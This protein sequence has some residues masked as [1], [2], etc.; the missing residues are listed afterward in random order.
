[1]HALTDIRANDEEKS[2]DSHP[3]TLFVEKEHVGDRSRNNTEACTTSESHDHPTAQSTCI[4]LR[5]SNA[6][7]ADES[8]YLAQE[9]NRPSANTTAERNPY[10][11]CDGLQNW[12][13]GADVGSLRSRRVKLSRKVVGTGSLYKC[14]VSS[15]D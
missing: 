15:G 3:R 2:V 8:D 6:D 9:Q 5:S 4:G 7:G 13:S 14:Y 11:G 1:M 10:Q 12:R